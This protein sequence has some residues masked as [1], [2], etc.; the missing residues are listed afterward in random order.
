MA[1][2]VVGT[3]PQ[4]VSYVYGHKLQ[5]ISGCTWDIDY[6]NKNS[7]KIEVYPAFPV[8]DNDEKSLAIGKSWV[9]Q[10][11]RQ[12]DPITKQWYDIDVVALVDV[13]ENKP[14]KNIKVCSLEHRGEGGRAYKILIDDKYYVDLRED[15]LVD[16]MLKAGISV[17]GILGGTYI[18][19]K[20]RNQMRII[21]VGSELHN[22]LLDSNIKKDLPKIR[23]GDL[24]VGAIYK[25]R[26]GDCGIFIDYVNTTTM[27]N[28]SD[29][30]KFYY[31]TQKKAMLFYTPYSHEDPVDSFNSMSNKNM[32]YKFK[33]CSSHNY[34]EKIGSVTI[35]KDYVF[36]IRS[37]AKKEITDDILEF[38]G[39]KKPDNNYSK[40]NKSTLIT[41]IVYYSSKLN[42]TKYGEPMLEPFDA[43][44]MLVFI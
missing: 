29:D 44:K 38:T 41:N 2:V 34:I 6:L 3:I 18:W 13:T 37:A 17:G 14:L 33:I 20:L 4:K 5:V 31:T 42:L 35:D 23:K 24:E 40:I 32:C 28:A 43:K 12:W 21:R 22:L 9:E 15:V 25:S 27:A 19:G 26:Q 7:T 11:K 1:K 8:S 16:V 39:H 30:F 10:N 36:L